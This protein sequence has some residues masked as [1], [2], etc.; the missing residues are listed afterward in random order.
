MYL[1]L[2]DIEIGNTETTVVLVKAI[3]ELVGVN[4]SPYCNLTI[5]DGQEE[6]S[7]KLWQKRKDELP[8]E[9][10]ELI[11]IQLTAQLYNGAKSFIV[12]RTF[13]APAD[14]D[15]LDYIRKSP[16]PPEDMYAAILGAVTKASKGIPSGAVLSV[17]DLVIRIYEENKEKLLYW[18][19]AKTMHHAYYGGLLYHTFTMIR[20]G[21]C[22]VRVYPKLDAELLLAG[23]ALHDIGKLREL[24]TT[25]L[26]TADYTAE[27][28]LFGHLA[29]GLQMIDE[30]VAKQVLEYGGNC[31]YDRTQLDALKH[32]VASH[33]GKMEWGALTEP[34]TLEA[35]MCFG[36]DYMDARM[37]SIS[38]TLDTMEDGE[39]KNSRASGK[40]YKMP[41]VIYP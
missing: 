6:T 19:A 24:E 26:G 9:A 28:N 38:E 8:Y 12:K 7:A 15:K 11:G 16:F 36:I 10:G 29:I 22:A 4:G 21:Q 30:C 17:K 20:S 25:P 3:E 23:I 33:H 14:A 37:N 27:G 31:P 2:K 40:V 18:A 41:P 34:K 5:S 1:K 39:I 32:I 35:Q 13:D